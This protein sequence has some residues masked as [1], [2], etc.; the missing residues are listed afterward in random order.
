MGH[1]P[2]PARFIID[3]MSHNFNHCSAIWKLTWAGHLCYLFFLG[4]NCPETHLKEKRGCQW[5]KK[6]A[7]VH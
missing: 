7:S 2:D 4:R 1:G 6:F 3:P 5:V